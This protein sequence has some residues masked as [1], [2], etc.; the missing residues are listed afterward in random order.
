MKKILSYIP[1]LMVAMAANM[2]VSCKDFLDKE[3]QGLLTQDIFPTTADDALQATNAVYN[4]LRRDGF[5]SGLFPIL[6]IMSDDAYKGSNPNDAAPTIGPYD[7]F[8]HIPSQDGL[9][10]WWATLYEGIKRSNVVI[11]KVPAIAMDE[12]LKKR[13]LAEARFLRAVF[14][15]DM[16]RAWGGVPKVTSVNVPVKLARASA[17][18]IYALIEEDLLFALGN[19]PEKSEYDSNQSGRATKGAARGYLAKSYL[20]HKQYDKAETY[21]LEVINSGQYSLETAFEKANSVLGEFGV[22][23]VFEVGAIGKEGLEN[24]GNP[25]GNVQGVRGSPNRGWG[26]NRPSMELQNAFEA[27]DPRKEATIIYL[28]E[29]I[30]GV[31]I[32]GDGTTP[33]ITYLPGTTTVAEIECY[34]Q[35]VWTPGT[36]TDS[37]FNHNRRLLRYADVL[38]M[39]AEVLNENGK[40][41][42]ALG[43]LNQVRARARGGS[44][45]ILADVTETNKDA[46]RDLILR[47][48]RVELALEGHRFW[49]LVRTGKAPVV[50]G[51]LGFQTGKNELLPIPQ[52]ERDLSGG[53]L[54][55]NPLY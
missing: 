16:V 44:P 18:E 29:V 34:N 36:N 52:T 17:D 15:F 21:A 30:D 2:L 28:Q 39:A 51:P 37:Q 27:D 4:I 19:L 55:Q 45:S 38:L 33:D 32:S 26:F 35:K 24:G 6:D 10:N 23:A 14:Y 20:F 43:Y 5:N 48:R 1:L 50:L 54:P 3:P 7:K 11:E 47:E 53:E 42:K 46:L 31:T 8:K 40:T 49:D 41:V 12:N 9:G 13:Y 25:Y 22:E